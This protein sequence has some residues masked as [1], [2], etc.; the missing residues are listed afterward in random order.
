[1]PNSLYA[2]LNSESSPQEI[3]FNR[4][5]VFKREVSEQTE[6]QKQAYKEATKIQI[7]NGLALGGKSDSNSLKYIGVWKSV[8][9]IV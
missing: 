6:Y 4:V 1:M 2:K 8:E 5:A 9:S 3:V 7:W